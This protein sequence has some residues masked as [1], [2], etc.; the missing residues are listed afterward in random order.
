L[1]PHAAIVA[2]D[3]RVLTLKALDRLHNM[4]TL[5]LPNH[6]DAF[7]RADLARGIDRAVER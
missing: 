6:A 1:A 5:H 4:R 7:S 3:D 2:I